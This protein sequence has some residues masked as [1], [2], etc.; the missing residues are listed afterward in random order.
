M[1]PAVRP[2]WLRAD[3]AAGGGWCS[4]KPNHKGGA[5]VFSSQ[6]V[7]GRKLG[8]GKARGMESFSG[9]VQG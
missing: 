5:Q 8:V 1:S 6:E 2:L 3:P 4:P 9:R 7:W